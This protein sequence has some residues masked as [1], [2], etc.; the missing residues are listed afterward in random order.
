VLLESPIASVS[1][2]GMGHSNK[3]SLDASTKKLIQTLA[4]RK[5]ELLIEIDTIE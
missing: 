3:I 5:S 1:K 4:T 2:V